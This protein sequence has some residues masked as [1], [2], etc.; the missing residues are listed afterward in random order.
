MKP[1]KG[2][3]CCVATLL[4]ATVATTAI[5]GSL[6][7]C[8]EHHTPPPRVVAHECNLHGAQ[9]TAVAGRSGCSTIDRCVMCPSVLTAWERHRLPKATFSQHSVEEVCLA[10]ISPRLSSPLRGEPPPQNSAVRRATLCS[11]LI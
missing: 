6:L 10:A 11:L 1:M 3:A 2:S 8:C 9:G 5:F 7:P 4:V